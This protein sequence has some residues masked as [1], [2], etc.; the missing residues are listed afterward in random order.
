MYYKCCFCEGCLP[1]LCRWLCACP[2][3]VCGYLP[4]RLWDPPCIQQRDVAAAFWL[5]ASLESKDG[6][7]F[8]MVAKILVN[9]EHFHALQQVNINL[10]MALLFFLNFFKERISEI[11]FETILVLLFI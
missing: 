2:A 7:D 10:K 8:S 4:Q 5:G 1:L 3:L 11:I 9:L 6:C